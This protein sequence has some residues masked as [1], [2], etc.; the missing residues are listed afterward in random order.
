M[1][2]LLVDRLRLLGRAA[3]GE[4]R[5][6][7]AR[8]ALGALGDL[9]QALAGVL[10]AVEDDV[11]DAL[12]QLGVEVVVDADHAGVDDA[13][14]HPRLDRVIE[15][16]GVDGFAHRVVAAEREA[17]VGDAARDLGARQVGLDP[18]RRL[19]EVDGVVVVLL[20]AGRDR[21]DVRVEDDVLGREADLV[22]E[23]PVGARA[24]L[25][26]A[27]EGVGLAL[28][29]ERHH[30]GGGAVAANQLGVV[31]ESVLA[32]LHRDR[33][34]DAL[35]LHALQAGLDHLPLR[36]VDHDRHARDLGLAGDEIQEADHR[37]L[38]I[39]HRLVHVDVDDLGAVLDLLARDA[40]RFLELAVQDQA[41]ERL[42]AGDVGPLADVDEQRAR[43]DRHRLQAGKLHRRD[44]HAA[45][46]S[47][48]NFGTRGE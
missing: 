25:G 9:D 17:H 48:L 35:A 6:V 29:V 31:A 8:L 46:A 30:D 12:A 26:L 1:R 4:P 19:D 5:R 44:H 47:S 2:E 7:V 20:D 38:R 24:D 15:E 13:H 28:L 40:E 41:R 36:A 23:D 43:A 22:D 39:E 45:A 11:L 18:A 21:E 14:V 33:V 16:H 34:D 3:P 42:R 37:R 10:A 32:L 27:R